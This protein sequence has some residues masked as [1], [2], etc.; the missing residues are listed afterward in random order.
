MHRFF[1]AFL[2]VLAS[3]ACVAETLID[4]TPHISVTGVASQDVRP[5]RARLSLA[6]VSERPTALEA[7][8]ENA[9]AARALIDELMARGVDEK[10][11]FT[12]GVSLSAEEEVKKTAAPRKFF[13]ARN[14]VVVLVRAIDK[15]GAIAGR[16][17]DKGANEFD[18]VAFEVSDAEAR[19]DK[20]RSE[21]TKDA[22]KR[23]QSY[24]D[25][26]GLKLTRVLE[27][28]P[29]SEEPVPVATR[30]RALAAPMAE[31]SVGAIPLQPGLQKLTARVN[32]TW[33]IGK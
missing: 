9:R 18:G 7:A 5:D 11:I 2:C 14:D 25:S 22:Q 26:L 4:S 32:V 31:K 29:E 23:A 20:L 21:A 30:A 27:I 1:L 33:G 16:L 8:A 17:I 19:L 24:V 28:R 15:A 3:S 12:E 10:D 6:V 13:R